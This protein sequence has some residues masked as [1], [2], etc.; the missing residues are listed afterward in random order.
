MKDKDRHFLRIDTYTVLS[1]EIV[2]YLLDTNYKPLTI[3]RGFYETWLFSTGRLFYLVN[4]RY[5]TYDRM[6]AVDYWNVKGPEM[7]KEDLGDYIAEKRLK[8]GFK[9]ILHFL[10]S[11]STSTPEPPPGKPPF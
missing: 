4:Y 11:V 9:S 8:P 10:K 7:I 1:R 2:I 3:S 6:E 5:N